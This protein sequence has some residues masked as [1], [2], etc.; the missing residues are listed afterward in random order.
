M[1]QKTKERRL[2]REAAVTLACA[3]LALRFFP[4]ERIFA[5]TS[6]QPPRIHRFAVDQVEWVAWA[7]GTIGSTRWMT[8]SELPCALA[9]QTML[10][11]RGITSSL[12]L[13]IARTGSDLA[14]HAWLERESEIVLGRAAAP[15]V[16]LV[17]RF[18]P[19]SA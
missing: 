3:R 13:G 19:E 10:S 11:R 12:C 18:G 15:S 9:A 7:I 16:V 14:A 6:R 5:W 4:P 1:K 17:A 2:L 8:A